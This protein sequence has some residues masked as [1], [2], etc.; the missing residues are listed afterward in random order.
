MADTSCRSRAVLYRMY[1]RC[2]C[3]T[4]PASRAATACRPAT[5]STW[6]AAWATSSP[7]TT[8][9]PVR[10]RGAPAHPAGGVL[11]GGGASS[12][13]AAASRP[14]VAGGGAG[15]CGRPAAL[16]RHHRRAHWLHRRTGAAALLALCARVPGGEEREAG[17]ASG[18]S[19]PLPA[20]TWL[21][22]SPHPQA[23][24]EPGSTAA[25]LPL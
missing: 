10:R 7:P 24:L 19:A 9:W 14:A 16:W 22:M 18:H 21:Q 25:L 23:S 11:R 12:A 13:A 8:P 4:R 2:C 5:A 20:A 3:S 15:H 17:E 1:R 6:P